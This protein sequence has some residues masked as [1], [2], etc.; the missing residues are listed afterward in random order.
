MAVLRYKVGMLQW[1]QS[2]L[3]DVKSKSKKRM[4]MFGALHPKSDVD[5]LYIKRKVGS[6]SLMSVERWVREEENSLSFYDNNSEENPIKG[7]STAKMINTEDT[8]TSVEF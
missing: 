6:R 4:T 3:K 8:V 7:L 2:K 1:K 5:R